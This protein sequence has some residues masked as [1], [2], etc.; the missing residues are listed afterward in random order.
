[1]ALLKTVT[2]YGAVTGALR[3]ACTAFLG[4]PYAAP[5]VGALRFAPPREPEA[6]QGERPC[7]Q[8]GNSP[9]STM[10][11]P[12]S[13]G[14]AVP[15]SDD[16]LYLNIWTPAQSPDE[17]L[18][19]MFWIFGGAF[20]GGTSASPEFVGEKLAGKERIDLT[21]LEQRQQEWKTKKEAA[22]AAS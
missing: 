2:K 4:I 12:A 11:D 22:E 5:P 13:Q 18:P 20:Q 6:W 8:Y 16:C 19:V 1:M 9:L 21:D 3:G 7:L 15:Q 10:G 17:K 14:G